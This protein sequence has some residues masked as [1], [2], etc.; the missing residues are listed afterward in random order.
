[1][2]HGND[3][4]GSLMLREVG[5]LFRQLRERQDLTQGE[6]AGRLGRHD[7]PFALDGSA[8]SR[9]EKGRRKRVAPDLAEALLE[10]LQAEP[11]ERRE[12]MAFLE[13][14]TT[15]NSPRPALWRRNADLLAPMR[16]EG[17][18]TLERRAWGE[19]NYEPR[20]VPG[21]LQTREYA[22]YVISAM[23]E[24][25]PPAKVKGLVD[26]RMDRQSRIAQGALRQLRA[27]V[28]EEGLRQ[29][30]KDPEILKGQLQ[31]LLLESENP[32]NT[33]RVLPEAVD[34][35]PGTSGA[36]VLM[37]FP[38]PARS[39]LWLEN[40]VSSGYF[41]EEMYTDAYT[42]AFTSLWQRALDPDDTRVLL[43]KMIKELQ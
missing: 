24:G 37:H 8:V 19:D 27:L 23:R 32:T 17:F 14:D 26:I 4:P 3:A 5:E 35:H 36:F 22:E 1:M 28:D 41:D 33:I 43:K 11:S 15:P 31:R 7:P 9:I 21:L 6:V 12:V 20:I 10:C 25:L 29:T 38:E 34:C 18:L 42:A 39:V 16:F 2:S 30:V 40:M 13:A